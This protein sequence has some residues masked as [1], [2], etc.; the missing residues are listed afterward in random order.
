MEFSFS[1]V[2]KNVHSCTEMFGKFQ[3]N[4]IPVVD[5]MGLEYWIREGLFSHLDV[6]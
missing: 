5:I 6:F 2:T 3:F 1:N 4:L